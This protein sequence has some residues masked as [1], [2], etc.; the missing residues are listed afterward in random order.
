[1]SQGLRRGAKGL[2][3]ALEQ[4]LGMAGHYLH[5]ESGAIIGARD[6]EAFSAAVD[7][8]RDGVDRL[9]ARIGRAERRRRSGGEP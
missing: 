8:L 5:E 7:D 1:M 9:E 3:G 4:A 2:R 6:I